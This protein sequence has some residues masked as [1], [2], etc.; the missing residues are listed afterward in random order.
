MTST[1]VDI[2]ELSIRVTD[3]PGHTRLRTRILA[4]T[5]PAADGVVF[6]I[7][8]SLHTSTQQVHLTAEFLHVVLSFLHLLQAKTGRTL[9]L[10][11]LLTKSDTWSAIQRSRMQDRV[12]T[13]LAREMDKRKAA[14]ASATASHAKLESIDA[15]PSDSS[16][17]FGLSSLFS[18][19]MTSSSSPR[20]V[21]NGVSLP[22]DE[23]EVLQSDVLNFDGA[24]DWTEDKLGMVI[25]FGTSGSGDN[26]Q[27][28][29][30]KSDHDIAEKAGSEAPRSSLLSWVDGKIR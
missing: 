1:T 23:Q 21:T 12:R 19:F 11:I 25:E 14:L 7:D 16:A 5:L 2:P 22:Q 13:A 8:P 10:L 6:C 9:P 24:F 20:P 30:A 3:V 15:L 28:S 18:G 29:D 27:S 17:P 26:L 4:D